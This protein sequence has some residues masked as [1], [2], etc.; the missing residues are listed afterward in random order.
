MADRSSRAVEAGLFAVVVVSWGLNYVFVRAGLGIEP[1]VVL[2]FLRS[3][4]GAVALLVGLGFTQGFRT[5]P[6]ADI[7]DALAIGV[8]NTAIFL[9]L[10]FAAA[11]SVPPGQT[12]VLVYTFPL[13]VTLVSGPVLREHP[14]ATQ[15]A[16]VAVG[17]GGVVL[18]SEPWASGAGALQPLAIVEL[19]GAAIS[20]AIGTVLFKRR[21]RGPTIFAASAWQ[22]VG[23]AA[24]LG[25]GAVVIGA[26]AVWSPTIVPIV[27]WLGVIGTAIAYTIFFRLLDR[28]PAVTVS[29]YTFLVPLVALVASFF[30]F[31]ER[32]SMVQGVGVVAV[33]GAIYLNAVGGDPRGSR[34]PGT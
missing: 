6:W 15:L 7:R 32:L 2:A 31:G 34:E 33:L 14:R 24:V 30:V 25:V 29:A 27:L 28:I 1:P 18:V 22:L 13:W 3:G 23:G 20:W 10:W 11:V 16:A 12:A 19:I 9:G 8:P 21:F 5:L 26:P 17:F 4:T